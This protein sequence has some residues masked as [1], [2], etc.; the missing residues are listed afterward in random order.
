MLD[1]ESAGTR[2]SMSVS[3]FP[4]PPEMTRAGARLELGAAMD[5]LAAR[6]GFRPST[7]RPRHLR[8][9]GMDGMQRAYLRPGHP[10]RRLEVWASLGPDAMLRTV[11][12]EGPAD[13]FALFG[14]LMAKIVFQPL[15]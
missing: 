2:Q 14:R 8:V 10:H 12:V 6:K 5:E 11:V 1:L 4:A 15:A 9:G 7:Q 13:G 3:A